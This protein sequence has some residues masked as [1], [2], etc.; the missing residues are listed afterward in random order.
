MSNLVT[1]SM[2][3][4]TKIDIKS[5][6][7]LIFPIIEFWKRWGRVLPIWCDIYF[8]ETLLTSLFPFCHVLMI[9]RRVIEL[10]PNFDGFRWPGSVLTK[11][12]IL[13][14][15]HLSRCSPS[16]YGYCKKPIVDVTKVSDIREV[17]TLYIS[18]FRYQYIF[19]Y[20]NTNSIKIYH[21]KYRTNYYI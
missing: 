12:F 3:K 21:K 10:S 1:I 13:G 16:K 17:A 20:S 9:R 5:Y 6:N 15:T 7:I 8:L 2:K 18:C 11:F 19:D 4:S 14:N